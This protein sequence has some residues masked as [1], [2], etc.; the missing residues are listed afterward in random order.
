MGK[1]LVKG[2]AE[3]EFA[4][5]ICEITFSVETEGTTAAKA[6]SAARREL[7]ELVS[8]LEKIGIRPDTLIISDDS[9]KRPYSYRD[10]NYTAK[11]QIKLRIPTNTALVNRIHGII[12]SGFENTTLDINYEISTETAI[13]QELTKLAIQDSRKAAELLAEA[14]GTKVVGID[15]ANLSDG[16]SMDMNIADLDLSIIDDNSNTEHM[17]YGAPCCAE[18]DTPLSDK[19]IPEKIKL[20]TD[21][22][23]VWM[24][25]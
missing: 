16:Y 3:Q 1:A 24:I 12:G 25:E 20:S 22:R 10:E 17:A 15:A 8:K 2:H 19:L 9:S 4:P 18:S 11:K 21:I 13:M 7:E 23:I 14:T 6:T 5:D